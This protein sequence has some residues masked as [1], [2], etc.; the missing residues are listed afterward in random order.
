MGSQRPPLSDSYRNLHR[1][2]SLFTGS[3][4]DSPSPCLLSGQTA[5]EKFVFCFRQSD[6]ATGLVATWKKWNFPPK[7]NFTVTNPFAAS[8]SQCVPLFAI[9]FAV[10]GMCVARA[11]L[12]F[13]SAVAVAIVR[14]QWARWTRHRT[15]QS[16]WKRFEP[17]DLGGS[18]SR[19]L[20]ALVVVGGV[21][22]ISWTT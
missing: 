21:C 18:C 11:E 3:A 5:G 7:W 15:G 4:H 13:T 20:D 19:L 8:R 16:T 6:M 9:R 14:R 12:F 2:D 1:T 22:W 17:W 10:Q